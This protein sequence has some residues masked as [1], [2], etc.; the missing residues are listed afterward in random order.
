V[1]FTKSVKLKDTSIPP[2]GAAKDQLM[3]PAEVKVAAVLLNV[4]IPAVFW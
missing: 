4:E 3:L 2:E 1:G